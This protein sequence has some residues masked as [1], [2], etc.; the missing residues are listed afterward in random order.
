MK[1]GEL[2]TKITSSLIKAQIKLGVHK[3]GWKY[4]AEY[5]GQDLPNPLNTG[6][7][8]SGLLETEVIDV[9]IYKEK[10]EAIQIGIEYLI[11]H[12]LPSG[13]WGHTGCY[14]K[15]SHRELLKYK[16]NMVST[17]FAIRALSLAITK[18]FR[19]GKEI[20]SNLKLVL[21]WIITCKT[22]NDSFA[23]SP[24]YLKPRIN[25]NIYAMLICFTIGTSLI[26]NDD[27]KTNAISIGNDIFRSFYFD[28]V[29]QSDIKPYGETIEDEN[30]KDLNNVSH[31]LFCLLWKYKDLIDRKLIQNFEIVYR[32]SLLMIKKMSM[33]DLIKNVIEYQEIN[34]KRRQFNHVLS[35]WSIIGCLESESYKDMPNFPSLFEHL[36]SKVSR[37]TGYVYTLMPKGVAWAGGLYLLFL[38]VFQKN[39]NL[40]DLSKKD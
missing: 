8:L 29:I 23:Y 36:L 7:V 40:E 6:E 10:Q 34:G 33:D 24:S 3:G 30:L 39:I 12:Q 28:S 32:N 19:L 13:G 26:P 31:A 4:F 14:N 16:G 5:N 35:I 25:A 27:I 1:I 2:I 38:S 17:Y 11:S 37:E 15:M 9:N 18:D 21:D 22:E 20:E